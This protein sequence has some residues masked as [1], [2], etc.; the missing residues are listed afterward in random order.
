MKTSRTDHT[1]MPVCRM[2]APPSPLSTPETQGS[3]RDSWTPHRSLVAQGRNPANQGAGRVENLEAL[4]AS[5]HALYPHET[6]E[7]SRAGG[8]V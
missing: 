4:P 1:N 7:C 6:A 8:E 2:F 5:A 3:A